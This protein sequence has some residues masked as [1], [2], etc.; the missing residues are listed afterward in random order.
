ME[1]DVL[2][3]SFDITTPPQRIIS[4]VPSLTETLFDLG[5]EEQ[6]VGVTDYCIFPEI[7]PRVRRIGGTKNPDVEAIRQLEPDL[8]Y[9]NVEENLRRHADA[10]GTFAPVFATEP[11]SVAAVRRL[12]GQLGRIHQVSGRAARWT[13]MLDGIVTGSDD[14]EN[15]LSF[16]CPIWKDPW[17][18]CGGD[19]YVSDLVVTA[20]GRNLLASHSRYPRIPLEEVLALKP[21]VLFLPDEP[22]EF[23]LGDARSLRSLTAA[24][25]VGPFPGHL[26]TWHGTR[27]I[28]GLEFL[29]EVFD[30]LCKR[31]EEVAPEPSGS[32]DD[33]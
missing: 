25:I 14:R 10:I 16:V 24:E 9:V 6:I 15:E 32:S 13:E 21:D 30:S 31:G 19:T 27:T 11:D 18:W 22:Y 5:L 26:F 28:A 33:D 1:R 17:M 23:G 20:G 2:G 12:L 7:P 29:N 8:V 3:R 4:L